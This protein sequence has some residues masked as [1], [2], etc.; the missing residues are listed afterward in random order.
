[1]T[2]DL[3]E[4]KI[5]EI[6][7]ADDTLNDLKLLSEFLSDN[8][9][10]VRSVTNGTLALASAREAQPDLILSKC[11]QNTPSSMRWG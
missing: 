9:Y 8:N 3:F 4:G 6:L 2:F 10:G 11:E 5:P 1:M 7:I